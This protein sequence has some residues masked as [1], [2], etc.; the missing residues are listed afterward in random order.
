MLAKNFFAALLI[1]SLAQGQGHVTPIKEEDKPNDEIKPDDN[2]H[3]D[4]DEFIEEPK[5]WKEQIERHD[6]FKK[7]YEICVNEDWC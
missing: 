6:D 4:I 3:Q 5:D 1:V 7:D 2:Q